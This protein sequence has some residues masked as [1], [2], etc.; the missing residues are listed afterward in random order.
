MRER[1]RDRLNNLDDGVS[2][3]PGEPSKLGK[4]AGWHFLL[5]REH[6]GTMSAKER[7]V[8]VKASLPSTWGSSPGQI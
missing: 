7:E 4:G 5:S 6:V 2:P 3:S 8:W 1:E